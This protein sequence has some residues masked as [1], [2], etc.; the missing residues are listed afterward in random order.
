MRRIL[1]LCISLTLMSGIVAFN[2]W[3]DLRT[4][5]EQNATLRAQAADAAT[6]AARAEAQL[7]QAQQA[8]QAQTEGGVATAALP[9][10]SP[11]VPPPPPA[12]RTSGR[13][14]AAR[15]QMLKDP[16]YR[17]AM[18]AQLRAGLLRQDPG[19]I[20]ALG[21]TE[22][23]GSRLIDLLARI[24]LDRQGVALTSLS[25]GP[26][27]QAAMQERMRTLQEADR[28]GQA[29]VA[30]LLGNARYQQYQDYVAQRP[31]R[32][33]VES[34]GRILE[35]KGL[36]LNDTQT[37]PLTAAFYEEQKREQEFSKSLA[38]PYDRK[39]NPAEQARREDAI[40]EFQ[41]DSNQRIV[42][43]AQQFLTAQQLETLKSELD[44]PLIARRIAAR[45]RREQAQ[46]Q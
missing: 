43:A 15:L 14:T 12:A 10:A 32:Q 28:K 26:L 2:L 4:E 37:K 46:G 13:A 40:L 41:A 3:L 19:L 33:R 35:V 16:E 42:D 39:E 38:G 1:L 7:Q 20:P 45:V 8:M 9:A 18:L 23:E 6:R 44:Q 30:A 24:Q 21:L 17:K 31:S 5:R 11:V 27:D 25:T 29:E 34:L 22:D 36:A